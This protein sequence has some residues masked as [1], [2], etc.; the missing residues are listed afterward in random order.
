ME[1]TIDPL[2]T[3]SFDQVGPYCEGSNPPALTTNSLEGID[4]VWGPPG[5]NT[6]IIGPSTFA[7]V[8]NTGQCATNQTMEIIITALQNPSFNQ[9]GPYCEGS[10]ISDLNTISIEGVTGNWSP[11]IDNTQ[12]TTYTFTPD[13][14]QCSEYTNDGDCDRPVGDTYFCSTTTYMRWR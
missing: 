10:V 3:P 8:P 4:G 12:T 13:A 14:G 2:V 6:T 5:I 7:F 1:I 9:I 11:S